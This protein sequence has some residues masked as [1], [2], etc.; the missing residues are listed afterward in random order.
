MA[1]YI[2]PPLWPAHGTLWS[3]LVSDTSYGELHAFAAQAGFPRRS[4]D[5]D[6]YDVPESQHTWAVTQGA[7]PVNTREIVHRLRDSGLRIKQAHRAAMRPIARMEYLGDQWIQ[8]Y[9]QLCGQPGNEGLIDPRSWR[10]LGKELLN[11]WG[12][13]HRSYHTPTHLEDVL[14]AL[15]LM[16]IRGETIAPVTLLAAWFHDA[17]YTGNT[18]SDESESANLAVSALT[19]VEPGSIWGAGPPIG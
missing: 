16:T 14:L 3:H 12:E 7:Q 10:D 15:N 17:I 4:F 5:L 18:V 19:A 11:R 6:H 1:I 2:D 8:L 13:P 9:H